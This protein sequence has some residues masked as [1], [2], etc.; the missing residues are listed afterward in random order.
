M[1]EKRI[2]NTNNNINYNTDI[3]QNYN[4]LIQKAKKSIEDYKKES[5]NEE[6]F[7]SESFYNNN[8]NNQLSQMYRSESD[9]NY[10]S[11]NSSQRQYSKINIKNSLSNMNNRLGRSTTAKNKLTKNI[12]NNKYSNK[13]NNNRK[14]FK[15]S[16]NDLY[17][18]GKKNNNKIFDDDNN[19][20]KK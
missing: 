1:E 3:T 8:L 18:E 16:F 14:N 6:L 11:P 13:I 10:F 15:K 4:N 5:N 7:R 9:Y 20:I 12:S 17:N 19:D 2:S